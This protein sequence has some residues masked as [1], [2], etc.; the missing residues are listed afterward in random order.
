M[1]TPDD[2]NRLGELLKRRRVLVD[3]R[4]RKRELFAE[5]RNVNLRLV[6]DIE[7]ARR[8][9]FTLA[10]LLDLEDAYELAQ[11]NIEEILAGGELRP[12]DGRAPAPSQD[13]QPEQAVP[14]GEPEEKL[15]LTELRRQAAELLETID[16]KLA[17]LE[18][19]PRANGGERRSA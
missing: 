5:E 15:T 7:T 4:Y 11:G 17:E 8:A 1:P 18:D 10:S 2:W 6:S 3:R 12:R 9:N 19:P 16:A 14:D 13:G